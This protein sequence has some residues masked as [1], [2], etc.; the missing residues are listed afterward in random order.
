MATPLGNHERVKL[1]LKMRLG[2]GSNDGYINVREHSKG[3][4]HIDVDWSPIIEDL[5]SLELGSAC[6][7]VMTTLHGSAPSRRRCAEGCVPPEGMI[8]SARGCIGYL[9][10]VWICYLSSLAWDDLDSIPVVSLL[11]KFRMPNIERYT[12]VGCPCIHVRLY[13][14]SRRELEG[15]RQRSEESISSFISRW[16]GK[17]AEIVDRPLQRVDSV[18]KSRPYF[19]KEITPEDVAWLMDLDGNQFSE[20]TNVDQLK[21][22]HHASSSRR[23]PFDSWT[24][25]TRITHLMMDDLMSSDFQIYHTSDAILGHISILAEILTFGRDEPP[26]EHDLLGFDCPTI[27]DF[28]PLFSQF[29][30]SEPPSL[31][32]YDVQN[33][34]FLVWSFRATTSSRF[35]RSKPPS[36]QFGRSEPPSVLT[37]E[38]TTSSQFG[39][40][41]P[42][43]FL[44]FGVQSHH[45]FSVWAHYLFSVSMLKATIS[46]QFERLELSYL[47]TYDIQSRP[48]PFDIQ[49]CQFVVW[50]SESLSILDYGVQGCLFQ[51]RHSKLSCL[52]SY[53]VQSRLSRLDVHSY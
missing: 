1:E 39:R 29:G 52:L 24:W 30:R 28:L 47:L 33:H 44:N 32:S 37:F 22:Y 14:V 16:Q 40:L 9:F 17:I 23:R 20:P 4:R 48:S 45:L 18:L 51:L 38:A 26:E 46:F 36:S 12:G 19:I 2:V 25:M 49:R 31:L 42:P 27:H 35:G 34:L 50:R 3:D 5:Y 8:D 10:S 11:D 21:R 6:V 53:D 41:E 7:E 43:S 13:N 15:F